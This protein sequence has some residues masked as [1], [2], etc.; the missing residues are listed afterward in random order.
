MAEGPADFPRF[1]PVVRRQRIREAVQSLA[2]SIVTDHPADATL[3][4]VAVLKGAVVFLA[5]LVRHLPIPV[6]I[7]FVR[8]RS[9]NG[10]CQEEVTVLD[11]LVVLPLYNRH[12][13][14][15]DCVLDKGR[16]LAALQARILARGPG[17]LRTCVLLS[18][19]REREMDVR[20]EYAGVEI[21]D[22]FVVGY[23]LDCDNRWRH[24]PYVAEY[25]PDQEGN[26]A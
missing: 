19:Q 14:L 18:K 4:I 13:L 17:S 11:D 15:L 25:D 3:V 6:E 22:V 5:D 7:E 12:V 23:G 1:T 20:V 16:T 2:A 24:L 8:V 26:E 21:P 10:T 9:Y